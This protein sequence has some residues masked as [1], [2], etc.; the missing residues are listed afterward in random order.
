VAGALRLQTHLPRF[1]ADGVT[2]ARDCACPRCDAGFGPSE[3]ERRVAEARWRE[4]EAEEEA[5]RMAERRRRRR[6][7]KAIA[8]R[9]ALE[10]DERQVDRRLRAERELRARLAADARLEAL[11]A[12]RRAGAP[13]ERAL[14]E[15]ESAPDA[16]RDVPARPG[17]RAS[18]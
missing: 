7:A 4:R 10:Q 16:A 5:R 1:E 8:L 15:A 6:L 13:V 2:H 11:L 18:A 9:D 12:R 14:A 17:T 3:R